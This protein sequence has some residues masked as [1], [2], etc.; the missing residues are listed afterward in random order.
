MSLTPQTAFS[1]ISVHSVECWLGEYRQS[2]SSFTDHW[3]VHSSRRS[4]IAGISRGLIT[5]SL[6]SVLW[7]NV[8]KPKK[9]SRKIFFN[10]KSQRSTK[11][12]QATTK[13]AF[14]YLSVREPK[15]YQEFVTPS[16]EI[17][18]VQICFVLCLKTVKFEDGDSEWALKKGIYVNL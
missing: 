6:F 16:T 10:M 8:S 15:H 11:Q 4:F 18:R 9:S 17:C 13:W 3:Q 2:G 5:A 12:P 1:F 7:A 14:W